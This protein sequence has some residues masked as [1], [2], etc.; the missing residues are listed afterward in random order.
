MENPEGVRTVEGDRNV[1]LLYKAL[2]GIKPSP[3]RLHSEID[4]FLVS[5]LG[6]KSSTW[7]Q[8]F[9]FV[10]VACG[11]AMI[12]KPYLDDL[13]LAESNDD[14]IRWIENNVTKRFK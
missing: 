1:C 10:W 8:C 14:Y 11:K 4:E 9:Y 7:Y 6:F 5:D 12:I 2:Y 13:L 3:Q